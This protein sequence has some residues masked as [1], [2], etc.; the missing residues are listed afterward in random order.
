MEEP[1]HPP[2]SLTKPPNGV[3]EGGKTN[4]SSGPHQANGRQES[5]DHEEHQYLNLIRR[6]IETGEV[7]SDRQ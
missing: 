7:Q 5:G 4:G 3:S 6:I 2:A 1:T